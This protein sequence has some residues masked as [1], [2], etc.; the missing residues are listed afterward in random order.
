MEAKWRTFHVPV[1]GHVWVATVWFG[2]LDLNGFRTSDPSRQSPC[3]AWHHQCQLVPSPPAEEVWLSVCERILPLGMK[4]VVDLQGAAEILCLTWGIAL[5]SMRLA[6][7]FPF[8]GISLLL[9]IAVV[10]LQTI[11][12][13]LFLNVPE[14]GGSSR[15]W[16][17]HDIIL[18][19]AAYDNIYLAYFDIIT[20]GIL[21]WFCSAFSQPMMNACC[22][23]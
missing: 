15:F 14:S 21:F 20:W 10:K 3:N 12:A 7:D 22:T 13:L 2:R 4:G 19:T 1:F 5:A 6:I 11:S 9:C 18:I 23:L 17:P 8:F 16:K